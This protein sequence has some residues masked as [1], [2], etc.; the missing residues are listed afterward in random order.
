MT[1][2]LE[3]L[4]LGIKWKVLVIT[5]KTQADLAPSFLTM[6]TTHLLAL[7]QPQLPSFY[8]GN[9]PSFFP[10]QDSCSFY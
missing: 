4:T 2:Q 10:H 3:I 1:L 8:P 7:F 5:Y 9:T 6:D